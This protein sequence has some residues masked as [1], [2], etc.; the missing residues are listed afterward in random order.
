MEWFG[1]R[2]KPADGDDGP[3]S[4]WH[5]MDL[6][7]SVVSRVPRGTPGAEAGFVAGDELLAI[8]DL[9]LDAGDWSRV[10]DRYRP[11]ETVDVLLAR[12]GRLIRLPLTFGRRPPG[13]RPL[14]RD[15]DASDA[16]KAHRAAWIGEEAEA[17]EAGDGADPAP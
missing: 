2:F 13:A 12:R 14:E 8:G 7:G 6:G 5:G 4:A 3:G 16:Q 15:P 1:L 17:E 10:D 9:R 11:N